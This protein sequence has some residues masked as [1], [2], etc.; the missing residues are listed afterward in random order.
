M[1]FVL[2]FSL[3]TTVHTAMAAQNCNLYVD[4]STDSEL[5]QFQDG[6]ATV[7]DQRTGLVWQR[8]LVG[9][10]FND[11]ATTDDFSDD[12]CDGSPTNFVRDDALVYVNNQSGLRLPNIKELAGI[13]ELQCTMPAINTTVFPNQPDAWVWSATPLVI[14]ATTDALS[15][16]F[17][18][19]VVGIN[20]AENSLMR[21]VAE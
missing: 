17:D 6:G 14:G 18:T 15:V 11:N 12:S 20:G 13:A 9:Q 1:K 4:S 10:T 7:F 8:C 3:L 21:L 16:S 5:F 2:F 19:G